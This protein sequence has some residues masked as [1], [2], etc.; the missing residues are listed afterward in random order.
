MK[1]LTLTAVFVVLVFSFFSEY[2]ICSGV[3]PSDPAF[4]VVGCCKC[5]KCRAERHEKSLTLPDGW[6]SG[7]FVTYRKVYPHKLC[8]KDGNMVFNGRTDRAPYSE[9]DVFYTHVCDKCGVTNQML[10]AHWPQFK[11]EWRDAK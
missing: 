11:R 8:F 1:K 6:H 10:N 5:F 3:T 9:T 4:Y 7:D 2:F